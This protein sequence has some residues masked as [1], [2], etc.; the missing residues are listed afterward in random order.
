[1]PRGRGRGRG[2]GGRGGRA[3]DRGGRRRFGGNRPAPA[4]GQ[5]KEEA[6]KNVDIETNP[7]DFFVG[8]VSTE[9]H[10]KAQEKNRP[11][12]AAALAVL[13]KNGV[14]IAQSKFNGTIVELNITQLRSLDSVLLA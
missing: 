8:V 13:Q 6:A 11:R 14:A 12:Y 1:M 4:D 5:A 10:M 3:G 2:R 9:E 7:K